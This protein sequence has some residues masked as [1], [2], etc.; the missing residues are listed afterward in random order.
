MF[1]EFLNKQNLNKIYNEIKFD[2]FFK[3]LKRTGLI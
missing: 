2:G 3:E 1:N